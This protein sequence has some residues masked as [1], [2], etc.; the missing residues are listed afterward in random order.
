VGERRPPA[1]RVVTDSEL[2]TFRSCPQRHDFAYRQRLR[3][4][5]AARALAVG[6]I[7]HSGMS[8]GIRAAWSVT[9]RSLP[10]SAR[11]ALA[12]AA[13]T[14]GVD[15]MVVDW[16]GTVVAH[17]TGTDYEAL[18]AEV[19]ET[20][21]TVKFMLEHYFSSATVAADM[22]TLQLV[23]TELPFTVPMRDRRG[24]ILRHL[25]YAGVRDAAFYDERY[26]S[27]VLHEHK[28][29]R[30]DPQR[31]ERRVEMD[32]QTAGYLHAL[33]E[34]RRSAG[35]RL[36]DGTPV[37][38]DTRLGHVAY[39]GLRKARPVPP[40]VNKDG[41]VSVA[42]C[43]TTPT[44]YEEALLAQERERRLPTTDKQREFLAELAGQGDRFFA[45][46]EW[47]RTPADVERW[48]SDAMVDARRIRDADRYPELR[49]RNP[50]HCNMPWSPP[51]PY[52]APCL[53]PAPEILA[54]F[55]VIEDP[56]AEVRAAETETAV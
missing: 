36:A 22:S 33:E 40:K 31:L 54:Q 2:Q 26:R 50:G 51:C 19:D 46:V 1:L 20:A 48:R 5:V 27:I 17:A 32:T 29:T 44:M 18:A 23:G 14:S 56:H 13:G 37:P 35:L 38:P 3:P 11:V 52:R 4:R 39:N 55:M 12:I 21:A 7:L 30:D 15:Q 8:A 6:S 53:D 45:R 49:T 9:A 10:T 42:Q 47:Q 24:V 16:A 25:R 34:E 41:H 43:T 28:S